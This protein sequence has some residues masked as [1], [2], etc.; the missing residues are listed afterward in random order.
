MSNKG[1]KGNSVGWGCLNTPETFKVKRFVEN[2]LIIVKTDSHD[3]AEAAFK[4]IRNNRRALKEYIRRYPE[5]LYALDPLPVRGD[6]PEIVC[7]MAEAAE[8]ASVGPMAAVAGALADIAA[9]QMV[10]EGA[11]VAVV[12]NG[13]EISARSD[14][15]LN[16]GIYAGKSPLS[17]KLGLKF[18]RNDL[19]AGVATSSGTVSHALSLGF[20][21]SVTVI[22]EDAALA[23]AAATAAGNAVSSNDL[24]TSIRSGLE[25]AMRIKGVWGVLVIRGSH[26]GMAGRLPRLLLIEGRPVDLPEV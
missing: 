26:V 24:P 1:N 2:K 18:L 8:R 5:F 16:I 13:G 9:E 7:R 21:D 11:T 25:A 3:A 14:S 10:R 15:D 19:P 23:D 22:A 4:S 20:A 6:A 17:G 12:E